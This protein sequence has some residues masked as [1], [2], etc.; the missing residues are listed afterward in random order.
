MTTLSTGAWGVSPQFSITAEELTLHLIAAVTRVSIDGVEPPTL[1]P[2]GLASAAYGQVNQWFPWVDEKIVPP[3][4]DG[5]CQ[6]LGV[7]SNRPT[8]IRDYHTI[9]L[10]RAVDY[11]L[12]PTYWGMIS[13]S[14]DTI[15][16]VP[17]PTG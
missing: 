15:L 8:P 5:V 7:P 2:G 13:A 17:P 6:H 10:M 14:V 1:G 12:A 11:V 16:P 9:A 4:Y 3:K